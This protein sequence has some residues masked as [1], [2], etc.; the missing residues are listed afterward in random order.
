M[1]VRKLGAAYTRRMM[2][3]GPYF[4]EIQQERVRCSECAVDLVTGVRVA[5]RQY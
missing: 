2:G 4:Q 3:V 5:Q 1:T